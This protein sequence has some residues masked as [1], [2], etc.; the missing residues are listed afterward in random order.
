[1]SSIT[2]KLSSLVIRTLSKPIANQIKAQARE[3]ERFRRICVSFAQ[4]VHRIDMRLRLG[5]LQNTAALEKQAA[6]EAAEA[7]AKKIKLQTP[8]VKTEAQTKAEELLKAKEKASSGAT[9]P[10][11]IPRIR[12]LS[13]GKAIDMGANFISETFLFLVGGG[14]IIFE[15]LRSRRKETSRREDVAER[16]V[17]LEESENAARAALIVLE[18]EI[19]RLQAQ[20][21]KR[22]VKELK[23]VLPKE[24]WDAGEEPE[25][26]PESPTLL[27]TLSSYLQ[28]PKSGSNNTNNPGPQPSPQAPAQTPSQRD[29]GSPSMPQPSK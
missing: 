25:P 21:E 13:E 26:Q 27:T 18:K 29:A 15:S 5:L 10:P 4:A 22:P 12:P 8:T 7:Q 2:L 9:K 17:E 24:I 20:L 14:L 23:R 1:M 6:R 28:W 3:H 11:P 19:L 16:L